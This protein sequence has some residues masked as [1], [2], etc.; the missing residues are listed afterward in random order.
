LHFK[1]YDNED[2][3]LEAPLP[4]DMKALLQQLKKNR[5]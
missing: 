1:N 4:K 5:G 2:F 3:L